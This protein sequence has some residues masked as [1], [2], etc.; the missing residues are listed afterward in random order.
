M[1]KKEEKELL[2]FARKILE[3]MQKKANAIMKY[4]EEK[5]F[6]IGKMI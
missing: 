4:F 6:K 2:L 3:R 1:D 5:N